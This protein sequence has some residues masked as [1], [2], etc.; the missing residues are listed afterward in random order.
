MDESQKL[1]DDLKTIFGHSPTTRQFNKLIKFDESKSDFDKFYG[2]R[3]DLLLSGLGKNIGDDVDLQNLL[4]DEFFEK[5]LAERKVISR[6]ELDEHGQFRI[7]DYREIFTSYNTDFISL[8]QKVLHKVL[9]NPLEDDLSLKD[10]L[11]D[12]SQVCNLKP[13]DPPT[14]N[15]IYMYSKI[16]IEKYIQKQIPFSVIPL[17]CQNLNHYSEQE[18]DLFLLVIVDFFKL[19]NI[20]GSIPVEHVF[21]RYMSTNTKKFYQHNFSTIDQFFNQIGIDSTFDGFTKQ[22]QRM[23]K[24]VTLYMNTM[25]KNSK[26][27]KLILQ[28][29]INHVISNLD[30]NSSNLSKSEIELGIQMDNFIENKNLLNNYL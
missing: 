13:G 3:F 12:Y 20:L 8:I 26:G 1:F 5:C 30:Y 27:Q 23:E 15:E 24:Y 17:L 16:G 29:I 18:L 2:G 22:K 21:L 4:F 25:H 7:A 19:R 10:V 14:F 11:N 9:S 28:K 6:T